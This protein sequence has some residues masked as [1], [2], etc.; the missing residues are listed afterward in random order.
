MH[1]ARMIAGILRRRSSRMGY[2]LSWIALRGG[3]IENALRLLKL[4]RTGTRIDN[5]PAR[6]H[7]L[8]SIAGGWTLIFGEAPEDAELAALSAD[9]EIVYVSVEDHV[10]VSSASAWAKGRRLWAVS[11]DCDEGSEHLDVQGEPPPVF[12]EIKA[13][14]LQENLS[15]DEDDDLRAD[16]VYDVPVDTAAALTGFR[17]DRELPSGA[18][19]ELLHSTEKPWWRRLLGSR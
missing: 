19:V 12:A 13:R 3:D 9:G 5:I 4:E 17:H 11:H 8:L 16:F 2:S 1:S 15:Q 10:M 18:T 7:G 14:A 6:D